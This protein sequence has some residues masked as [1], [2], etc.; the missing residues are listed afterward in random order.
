MGNLYH[1]RRWPTATAVAINATRLLLLRY[2]NFLRSPAM[3]GLMRT[4]DGAI[5][6]TP[7]LSAYTVHWYARN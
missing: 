1:G 5:I 4:V 7:F 6:L 2:R 3:G